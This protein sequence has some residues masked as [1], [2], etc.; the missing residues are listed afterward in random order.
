MKRS[1]YDALFVTMPP[2]SM[3]LVAWLAKRFFNKPVLL[4][5][6][7]DWVDTPPF[8]KKSR[9][10]QAIGRWVERCTVRDVDRVVVVSSVSETDFRRRYPAN[11]DSIRMI[12]NGCDLAE[13]DTVS[14][15]TRDVT[16]DRLRIVHAGV[17]MPPGRDPRPFFE[18]LARLRETNPDAYAAMDVLFIGR[19]PAETLTLLD[20]LRLSDVVRVSEY[21]PRSEFWATIRNA[22]IL[23]TVGDN[24]F[25][26]MVPGKIYDY[27]AAQRPQLYVGPE[28]AASAIVT[29]NRLGW[30]IPYNVGAVL[31]CIERIFGLWKDNALDDVSLDGIVQFDRQRLTER[32]ATELNRMVAR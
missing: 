15:L 29:D 32:L 13:L 12:P 30:V 17:V 18:A 3:I 14:Q 7:D 4:D 10:Q 9:V 11:V 6:R 19:L 1:V 16:H 27:W 8:Y 28:G 23:L 24:E 5:V 22:D 2:R 25:P 26:S 31:S 20:D 21:M